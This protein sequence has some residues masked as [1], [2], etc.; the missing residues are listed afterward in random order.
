MSRAINLSLPQAEVRSECQR[1][2]ISISAIE[3][4]LSGGT[5]LVCT[6]GGAAE[7][8]RLRFGAHIIKG[9]VRR[10]PFYRERAPL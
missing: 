5:H 6:T 8:A 10:F 9:A 3:P 7:E 4:L 2:G 1:V